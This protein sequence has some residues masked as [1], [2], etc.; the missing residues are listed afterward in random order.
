META[1]A[2][3]VAFYEEIQD[4]RIG[5]GL[6][7]SQF[8]M[9]MFDVGTL[10]KSILRTLMYDQAVNR[11]LIRSGLPQV[12]TPILRIDA[13]YEP[14]I[15]TLLRL[16][17]SRRYGATETQCPYLLSYEV[18]PLTRVPLDELQTIARNNYVAKISENKVEMAL[19][20]SKIR[21]WGF[22]TFAVRS[23]LND[24][25]LGKIKSFV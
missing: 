21:G 5:F 20:V 18:L 19:A 9:E 11:R 23:K 14:C 22:N 25:V 3:W 15:R 8:G 16:D 6:N 10:A 13:S 4:E 24:D 17:I 1:C 12:I 2:E 7:W